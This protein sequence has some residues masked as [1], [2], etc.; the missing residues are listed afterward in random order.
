M[1]RLLAADAQRSDDPDL[2]APEAPVPAAASPSPIE[3]AP[4]MQCVTGTFAD[5]LHESA[6]AAQLYAHKKRAGNLKRRRKRLSVYPP[7]L[8]VLLLD[9]LFAFACWTLELA[10]PVRVPPPLH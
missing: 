4:N 2:S 10:G 6:F 5:P 1:P 9:A 8:A 7:A 3:T